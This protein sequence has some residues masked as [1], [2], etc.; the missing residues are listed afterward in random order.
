ML[1]MLEGYPKRSDLILEYWEVSDL[2][3]IPSPARLLEGGDIS[4]IKNFL[5][6]QWDL[7]SQ[8][9][10]IFDNF[11]ESRFSSQD[12]TVSVFHEDRLFFSSVVKG[13]RFRRSLRLF[14]ALQR[15]KKFDFSE[16]CVGSKFSIFGFGVKISVKSVMVVL[17]LVIFEVVMNLRGRELQQG[18]SLRQSF[19]AFQLL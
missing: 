6:N 11:V 17:M 12:L 5:Q 9:W 15:S 10:V 16:K 4:D 1:Q 18:R 2:L 7:V 13:K 3:V 8:I 19:W 14:P